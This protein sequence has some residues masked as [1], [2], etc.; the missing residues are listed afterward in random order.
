M[1]STLICP[2]GCRHKLILDTRHPASHYGLGV[3]RVGWNS[4]IIDGAYMLQ[5]PTARIMTTDVNA[6]CNALALPDSP[7]VIGEK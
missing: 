4:K 3:M 7:Q 2:A 6:V 5:N 1:K